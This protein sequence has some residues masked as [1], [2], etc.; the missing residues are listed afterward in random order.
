MDRNELI[1]MQREAYAIK[2]CHMMGKTVEETAH[3]LEMV[4]SKVRLVYY[5]IENDLID[6]DSGIDD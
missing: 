4:K 2:A 5:F 3:L 6:F 1:T